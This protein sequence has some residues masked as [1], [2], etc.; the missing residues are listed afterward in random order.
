MKIILLIL[1]FVATFLFITKYN[2][3]EPYFI[4]E[5]KTITKT[6]EIKPAF[7]SVTGLKNNELFT[8]MKHDIMFEIDVLENPIRYTATLT[9][10]IFDKDRA[11]LL[12]QYHH[13]ISKT[14]KILPSQNFEKWYFLCNWLKSYHGLSDE[15]RTYF[16][17]EVNKYVKTNYSSY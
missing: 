13:Y 14:A 15:A 17:G 16:L 4:P 7:L 9:P 12:L 10:Y 5:K 11:I 6:I 3:S 8:K 1:S 2:K